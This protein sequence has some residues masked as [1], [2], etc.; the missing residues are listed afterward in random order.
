MRSIS[1]LSLTIVFLFILSC[2]HSKSTTSN[3]NISSGDTSYKIPVVSDLIKGI[4]KSK[5]GDTLFYTFDNSVNTMEIIFKSET[6]KLKRELT[7]SGIK[8][9][10]KNYIYTEWHGTGVLSKNGITIFEVTQNN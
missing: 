9:S 8:Y 7:A 4:L 5:S 1:W 3:A 2:R 6:I 10:N